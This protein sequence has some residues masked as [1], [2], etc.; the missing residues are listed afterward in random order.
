[1]IPYQN[2]LEYAAQEVE[3]AKDYID[4]EKIQSIVT[5]DNLPSNQVVQHISAH[6]RGILNYLGAYIRK[7][8]VEETAGVYT[9]RDKVVVDMT[10]DRVAKGVYALTQNPAKNPRKSPPTIRKGIWHRDVVKVIDGLREAPMGLSE[11]EQIIR[12]QTYEDAAVML[13]NYIRNM[14]AFVETEDGHRR[15]RQRDE[16]IPAIRKALKL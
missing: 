7:I 13:E 15:T 2:A 8:P 3:K 11:Y 16:Y 6:F 10:L 1:M 14:P 12:R 4:E 9:K 5:I